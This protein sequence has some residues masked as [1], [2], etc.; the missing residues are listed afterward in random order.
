[1]PKLNF[2]NDLTFLGKRPDYKVLFFLR[3]KQAKYEKIAI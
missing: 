2:D 1:M 3:K